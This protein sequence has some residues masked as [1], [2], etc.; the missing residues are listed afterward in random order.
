[1][2]FLLIRIIQIKYKSSFSSYDNLSFTLKKVGP[3]LDEKNSFMRN[4]CQ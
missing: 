2:L 4:F 3:F 1:M